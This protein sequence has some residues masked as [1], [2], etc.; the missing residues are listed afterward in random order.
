M[1]GKY[2]INRTG[3]VTADFIPKARS[4]GFRELY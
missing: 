2:V 4:G 1:E 3:N